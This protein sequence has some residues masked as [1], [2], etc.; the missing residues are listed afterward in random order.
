MTTKTEL[1]ASLER[2]KIGMMADRANVAEASKYAHGLLLSS[3]VEERPMATNVALG[4][5][6]NTLLGCIIELVES[7]ED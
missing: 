3:S 1:L 2:A 7:L 4:V 6:H 5:Y